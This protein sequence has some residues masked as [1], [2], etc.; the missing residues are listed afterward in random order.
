M[1]NFKPPCPRCH[2]L[3]IIKNGSTDHKKQKY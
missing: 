1:S 3:N 2:S